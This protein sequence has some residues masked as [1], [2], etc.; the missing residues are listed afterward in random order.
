MMPL[1]STVPLTSAAG[2]KLDDGQSDALSP[3]EGRREDADTSPWVYLYV[4]RGE[5]EAVCK[6]L[7]ESFPV[8]VHTS[9]AERR[10]GRKTVSEAR[11]TVG[12]L[13]FVHGECR[14]VQAA[15]HSVFPWMFLARD[16][17]SGS[18]AIVPCGEMELFMRAA[19]VASGRLRVMPHVI[20]YYAGGHR[21]MR[22]ASG[23]LAGFEGYCVRIARDRC[24]VTTL[25]GITVSIGGVHGEEL[26]PA[27]G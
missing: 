16:C 9:V 8:F 3:G 26:V 20:E 10:R 17:A 21:M 6:L 7:R 1:D 18:T 4:R 14:M 23:P 5:L 13:V 22:I 19:R 12:G 24:L 2:G 11:P 15:L 25:G 27:D